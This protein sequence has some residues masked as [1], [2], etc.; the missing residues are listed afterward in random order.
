MTPDTVG[1]PYGYPS[2]YVKIYNSESGINEMIWHRR[3]NVHD[4]NCENFEVYD[5]PL[6]TPTH[7]ESVFKPLMSS[8]SRPKRN[9]IET[10]NCCKFGRGSVGQE[11]R[12][13]GF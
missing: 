1:N 6:Y 12:L 4:A 5:G 8:L 11:Q 7:L 3:V 10:F 13:L 2:A 9:N